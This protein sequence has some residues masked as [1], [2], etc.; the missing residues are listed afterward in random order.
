MSEEQRIDAEHE[1]TKRAAE[2]QLFDAKAYLFTLLA[3]KKQLTENEIEIWHHL[4]KD[5]Q[6]APKIVYQEEK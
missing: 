1:A 5:E 3:N 2:K 4:K 6:L